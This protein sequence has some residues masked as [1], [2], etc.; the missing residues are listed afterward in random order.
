MIIGAGFYEPQGRYN[1]ADLKTT[2]KKDGAGYVL[3]G[4]KAVVIGAPYATHFIVTAPIMTRKIVYD[5][6]K[7]HH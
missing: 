6:P 4:H 1:L 2:A 7:G 5:P 3:N